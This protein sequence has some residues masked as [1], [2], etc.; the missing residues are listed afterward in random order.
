MPVAVA[1]WYA[2]HHI[3]RAAPALLG[4]WHVPARRTDRTN[5]DC[6][7]VASSTGVCVKHGSLTRRAV[8]QMRVPDEQVDYWPSTFR[9]NEVTSDEGMLNSNPEHIEVRPVSFC[10]HICCLRT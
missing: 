9:K 7:A 2:A 10:P 1:V 5:F 4:A 8:M 6:N 3:V